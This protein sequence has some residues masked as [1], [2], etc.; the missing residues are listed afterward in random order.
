MKTTT[1]KTLLN[2]TI[3]LS[4]FTH[5]LYCTKLAN[6]CVSD[7]LAALIFARKFN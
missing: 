4:T 6:K 3:C 7:E 1:T 5:N 2:K